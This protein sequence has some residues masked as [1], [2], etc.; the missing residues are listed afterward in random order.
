MSKSKKNYDVGYG[1]P[2]KSHQWKPGES[3]NPAG[4]KKKKKSPPNPMPEL[5]AEGLAEKT[6]IIINGKKI[7]LSFGAAMAKNFLHKVTKG[8][9]SEQRKAFETLSK[10]GVFDFQQMRKN[11]ADNDDNLPELTEEDRRLLQYIQ[12]DDDHN[13]EPNDRQN[14]EDD[15]LDDEGDAPSSSNDNNEDDDDPGP[16]IDFD[17]AD[18]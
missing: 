8:S 10:L 5:F 9:L 2:P 7:D 6:S 13:S 1:K 18:D 4:G 3:G 14:E 11:E 12:R 15:P 16:G 17:P